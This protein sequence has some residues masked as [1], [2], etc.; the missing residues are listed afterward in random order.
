MQTKY[1]TGQAILIPAKIR[2]AEEQN[3][4]I[5]YRVDGDFWEGIPEDA[6]IVDE[7]AEKASIM[8]DFMNKLIGRDSEARY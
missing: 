6:I 8:K 2:S 5:L 7:N 1:T 4:K 3:G